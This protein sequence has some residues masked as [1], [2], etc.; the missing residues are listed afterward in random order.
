MCLENPVVRARSLF[1]NGKKTITVWKG[2]RLN[3]DDTILQ[4]CLYNYDWVVGENL[5]DRTSTKLDGEEITEKQ[6]HSGFHVWVKQPKYCSNILV[7]FRANIKDYV[8]H[9]R[10]LENRGESV[11]TKLTLTKREYNRIIKSK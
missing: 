7:A 3:Y 8:C 10:R 1:N 9:T 11:F 5:S 4:S 6:V 2:L